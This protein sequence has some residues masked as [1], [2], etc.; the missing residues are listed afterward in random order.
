MNYTLAI[1]ECAEDFAARQDPAR[2]KSYWERLP[3][4]LKALRDAG[5]FVG[6]AGLEA[7]Q[8]ATTIRLRDGQRFVQDG[9][10]PDAKEQL[11]GFFI[12]N[13]PDLERAL[14]W[15]MRFPVTPGGSIEVRPNLPPME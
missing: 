6:G 10:Y 14:E 4:F 5:V 9:P 13:V 2:Q 7:P 8:T 15:A 11:A 12:V 3:P 1:Y